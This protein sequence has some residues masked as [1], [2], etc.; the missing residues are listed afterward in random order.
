MKSIFFCLLACTL[1]LFAAPRTTISLDGQWDITDS[2]DANALPSAF[3][4]KVPVPGLVHSSVPSFPSVDEFDSRQVIQNRVSKGM[5]PKSALVYNAGVSRQDRDWFWYRR[6]FKVPATRA[7]ATLRINK[8]QFGAAVWVNG[9]KIGE[10]LP[11]FSAAVLDVSQA[12]RKGDNEI[13]VRVGAHPGVLPPTVTAGT[14]FEKNR[15][16]PGIYDS[17]SLHLSD[18]PA[19]ETVQVA[20]RIAGG[21]VLVQ[22]RLRNHGAAPVTFALAQSIHPWKSAAAVAAAPPKSVTLKAGEETTV[23]PPAPAAGSAPPSPLGTPGG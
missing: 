4:H 9:K 6:T 16:T 20:P 12:I 15:W 19:I 14:D 22:T 3:T 18:N 2:K 1:S 23:T 13:V 7:V 10:H 5:L 8:A 17:V 11:C 21:S